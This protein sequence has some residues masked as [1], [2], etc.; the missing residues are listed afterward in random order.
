VLWIKQG[1]KIMEAEDAN[2]TI[3]RR[4]PAMH[5]LVEMFCDVELFTENFCVNASKEIL[6]LV[7]NDSGDYPQFESEYLQNRS[8]FLK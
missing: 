4:N 5:S 7:I 1:T 8:L 3:P 2:Y 6:Q